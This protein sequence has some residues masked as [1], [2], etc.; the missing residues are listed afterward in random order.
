MHLCLGCDHAAYDAKRKLILK[1]EPLKYNIW[2][3][4]HNDNQSCHYPDYA[5]KVAR[6]I[7]REGG[8]GILLCGSGIGVSMA[9]NRFAGIRGALCRTVE[10]A[11]FSRKHNHANVLCLGSR[12]SNDEQIWDI[13]RVWLESQFEGGRHQVRI[14]LF[15]GLGERV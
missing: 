1:L 3:L 8:L 11:Q 2:D 7:Q 14:D 6:H 4:G 9:V 10:E 5:F 15:D 12:I 13:T